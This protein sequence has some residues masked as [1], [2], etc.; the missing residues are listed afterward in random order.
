[1]RAL[2]SAFRTN[3]GISPSS[4]VDLGL[5]P[6]L[7]PP[8]SKPHDLLKKVDQNFYAFYQQKTFVC[9]L[10]GMPKHP[11]FL[12]VKTLA[13]DTGALNTLYNVLLTE[14]VHNNEGD[15]D[16]NTASILNSRAEEC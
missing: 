12:L 3:R 14:E 10:N 6:Y 13:C 16:K 2:R 7:A 5:C 9:K 1:M 4:E 15:D 11:I 8:S